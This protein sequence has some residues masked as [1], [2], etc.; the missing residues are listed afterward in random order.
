MFDTLVMMYLGEMRRAGIL[1]LADVPEHGDPVFMVER[2]VACCHLK[3]QDTNC[4]PAT[5][6]HVSRLTALPL[7]MPSCK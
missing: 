1:D 2:R 3:D 7:H 6:V 5:S 4:P